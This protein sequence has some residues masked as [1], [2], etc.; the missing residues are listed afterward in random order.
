LPCA[1]HLKRVTLIVDDYDR[2]IGFFVDV[3]SP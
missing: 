2:A 3:L 1:M